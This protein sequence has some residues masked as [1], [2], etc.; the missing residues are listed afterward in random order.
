LTCG[1]ALGYLTNENRGKEA[2]TMQ[3]LRMTSKRQVT[4]PARVCE[5]LGVTAGDTLLLEKTQ[6][7]GSKAWVI[8]PRR[9]RKET[10]FKGLQKYAAG[11]RHSMRSVRQS[12]AKS[13]KEER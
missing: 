13:M 3:A 9:R 11:K 10:W 4:F 8:R 5:E 2:F 6:N 7:K 1:D 12:I